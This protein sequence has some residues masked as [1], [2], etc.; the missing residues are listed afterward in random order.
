MGDDS[1]NQQKETA[2]TV[3]PAEGEKIAESEKK[4]ERGEKKKKV[5]AS[6]AQGGKREKKVAKRTRN[7]DD[8]FFPWKKRAGGEHSYPNPIGHELRLPDPEQDKGGEMPPLME[9]ERAQK[10]QKHRGRLRY[11]KIRDQ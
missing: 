8:K 4:V 9:G 11:E 6:E 7:R 2:L 1:R 3:T 5:T 10:E